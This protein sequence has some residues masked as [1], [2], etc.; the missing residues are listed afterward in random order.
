MRKAAS[1]LMTAAALTLPAGAAAQ[2][3]W[4]SPM[5]LPPQPPAGFGIFLTDMH[6]AGIGVSGTWRGP[7]NIGFRFGLSDRAG[8]DI[9]VH[10]GI[11]YSAVLNRANPDF[12]IDIDWLVGAGIGA[13]NGARLSFPFGI[14]GGHTF[15]GEGADFTPYLSPRVVLDAFLGDDRPGRRSGMDLDFAIDLGIDL[16]FSR[17]GPI[18]RFGAA[19]GDR[20]AI[21]IGLV[22]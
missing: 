5:L 18:I 3:A 4:D 14:T 8:D 7:G 15:R 17:T 20:E 22:F 11:D 10:G 6:A 9:G 19:L 2:V 21:A 13:G 1:A 12:P 16:R